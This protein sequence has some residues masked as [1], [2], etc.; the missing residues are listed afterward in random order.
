MKIL[1]TAGCGFFQKGQIIQCLRGSLLRLREI[2]PGVKPVV[3]R[4]KPAGI[5]GHP[6]SQNKQ[7]GSHQGKPVQGMV[8]H[9]RE[10]CQGKKCCH[11]LQIGLYIRL[12]P[13]LQPGALTGRERRARPAMVCQGCGQKRLQGVGI[14]QGQK[15][16]R[17]E[18][19][20]NGQAKHGMMLR[21][22]QT[23]GTAAL[24]G[25]CPDRLG[26][27]AELEGIGKFPQIVA[28]GQK[29]QQR[30]RW[31]GS[32]RRKCLY[33]CLP[34]RI[35]PQQCLGHGRC[36][37]AMMTQMVPVALFSPASFAPV[38]KMHPL[39]R[40]QATA[41]EREMPRTRCCPAIRLCAVLLAGTAWAAGRGRGRQTRPKRAGHADPLVDSGSVGTGYSPSTL[42]III[43]WVAKSGLG[44]C[45]TMNCLVT[46]LKSPLSF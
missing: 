2:G 28:G 13:R 14:G 26:R 19:C 22:R 23:Y 24:Q 37:Q 8:V 11:L 9:F 16:L 4:S 18:L 40:L 31:P 32:I 35:F 45:Q 20:P 6:V 21:W 5:G 25:W 7:P 30:F 41:I 27:Q 33:L 42:R 29:K 44:C 12:D 43:C 34:E 38:Y 39:P 10:R 46:R 36:I 17:A 3:I 1:G 15:I